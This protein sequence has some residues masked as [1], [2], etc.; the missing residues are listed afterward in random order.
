MNDIQWRME[1]T[2]LTA[3]KLKGWLKEYKN[4]IE[5]LSESKKQL[6]FK[7]YDP[8][9]GITDKNIED[10]VTLNYSLIFK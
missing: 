9:I 4:S 8:T 3:D 2:E 10:F 5:G 6:F 7:N 1:G